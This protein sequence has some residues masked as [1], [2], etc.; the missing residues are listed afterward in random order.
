MVNSR[1]KTSINPSPPS[2]II[3]FE[4]LSRPIAFCLLFWS[5]FIALL[6][7]FKQGGLL[8][9]C[10]SSS[11][12]NRDELSEGPCPTEYCPQSKD[13]S[14]SKESVVVHMNLSPSS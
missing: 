11:F 10:S 3:T 1:H 12:L 9:A 7:S 13:V 4:T 2:R 5:L 8:H 6:T 14:G